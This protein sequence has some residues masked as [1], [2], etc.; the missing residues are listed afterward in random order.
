MARFVFFFALL[1]AVVQSSPTPEVRQQGFAKGKLPEAVCKKVNVI[2][3]LLKVYEATP[4]CS[5]Y[6][7]LPVVT[8][9]TTATTTTTVTS[10]ERTITATSLGSTVTATS[11]LTVSSGTSYVF[12]P[13]N[14]PT[15]DV[16]RREQDIEGRN[17]LQKPAYLKPFARDIISSGCKCLDIPVK[18]IV[19]STTST[20]TATSIIEFA[21]VITTLIYTTTVVSTQ[22]VP[23]AT[24]LYPC[25]TPIPT[26]VPTLPYGDA[27]SSTDLELGPNGRFELSEPQGASAEACCNACFFGIQNCIQ[28]FW[29]SYQGCVYQTASA[30]G[31]GVGVSSSCPSGLFS[32]LTYGLDKSSAFRSTGNFAGPCGLQYNN[33]LPQ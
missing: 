15:P 10:A 2:I 8:S 20:A 29:Y 6:L 30:T 11:T 26:L 7:G 13:G 18:T 12:L 5:V 22:T 23:T 14:S 27:D 16:Q 19:T 17:N 24:T 21:T 32:G 3:T 1:A 31:S 25:A 33:L 4:F 28:A 9:T